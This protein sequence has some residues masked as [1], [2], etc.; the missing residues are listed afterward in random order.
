VVNYLRVHLWHHC[1]T[2]AGLYILF[3]FRRQSASSAVNHHEQ[4]L[5]LYGA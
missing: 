2:V 4:M 3:S 5:G 1:M